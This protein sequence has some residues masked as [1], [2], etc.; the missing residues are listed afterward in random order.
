[1]PGTDALKAEIVNLQNA[2]S[3]EQAQLDS[4]N[5]SLA[6]KKQVLAQMEF[7]NQ[8]EALTPEEIV[9]INGTI[10]SDGFKVSI[11]AS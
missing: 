11:V 10:A 7:I 3:N 5:A 2:I 1:M 9:T 4:D 8:I 6:T